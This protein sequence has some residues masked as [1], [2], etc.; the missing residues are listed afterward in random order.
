MRQL[1]LIFFLLIIGTVAITAVGGAEVKDPKPSG[2]DERLRLRRVEEQLIEELRKS[3]DCKMHPGNLYCH[4]ESRGLKLVWAGAN[5]PGGGT[6]Y[7]HSIGAGQYLS[8]VGC[9]CISITFHLSEFDQVTALIRD[10]ARIESI[11][12]RSVPEWC[13]RVEKQLE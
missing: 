2:E 13:A 10:D 12:D 11:W 6:I 5:A 1:P 9:R 3:V 4:L 7:V 8:P